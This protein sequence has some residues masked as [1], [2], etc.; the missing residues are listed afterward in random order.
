MLLK[1][2]HAD[3]KPRHYKIYR[4]TPVLSMPIVT[5]S[6]TDDYSFQAST[7]ISLLLQVRR[8][9][10]AVPS[11]KKPHVGRKGMIVGSKGLC[12]C[13]QDNTL[14]QRSWNKLRIRVKEM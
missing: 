4:N 12:F 6:M 9:K 1:G 11:Q 14:R 8:E 5:H 13:F 7:A 3:L 2:Q 10:P